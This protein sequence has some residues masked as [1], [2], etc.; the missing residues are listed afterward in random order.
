MYAETTE[1]AFLGIRV[2]AKS[3]LVLKAGSGFQVRCDVCFV[4]LAFALVAFALAFALV[5]LALVSLVAL[6]VFRVGLRARSSG[7]LRALSV[8]E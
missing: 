5:A 1:L 2:R 4:A 3:E 7:S 8:E 6:C